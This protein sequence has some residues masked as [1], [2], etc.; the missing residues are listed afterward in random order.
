LAGW[1]IDMSR[2][3]HTLETSP[4]PLGPDG[5]PDISEIEIE[6]GKPVDGIYSERQM[7]LL[8]DPLYDSWPGPSKGPGKGKP[9]GALANVGI[10]TVDRPVIVPDVLLSLRYK[11]GGKDPRK[12]ENLA[13]FVWIIGKL[14]EC[15]IEI[16]SNRRGKE[17]TGKKDIYQDI[18]IPYYVVWDVDQKLRKKQLSVFALEDGIYQDSEPW[19][20]DI[21]LGLRLWD[22]DF[23][24]TRGPFI[25]WH[26]AHDEML[27]TGAERAEK[28]QQ[29]ALLATK[30]ARNESRRAEQEA[31]RAEQE[32]KQ[33]QAERARA[34]ALAARLR[35]LGVDPDRP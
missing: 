35:Q 32:A 24:G 25:R 15:A 27:L 20:P 4:Y 9:F 19:F 29:R 30:K 21:E 12:K 28:E 22:S 1:S 16:V 17:L 7:R 34:D 8:V 26:D 23:Q 18:G 5:L 6:D 33:A 3:S 11:V 10:F 2:S 14:P 13:Y 31:K